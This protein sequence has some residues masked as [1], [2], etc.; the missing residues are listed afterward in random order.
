MKRTSPKHCLT[1]ELCATLF[2]FRCLWIPTVGLSMRVMGF[3]SFPS[4]FTLPST[5]ATLGTTTSN[6]RRPHYGVSVCCVW[7][8]K[9]ASICVLCVITQNSQYL[10]VVCDY[11]KQPV[12][13]CCVWL[14]KTASICVWLLKT[15]SICVWLL[16]AA[17]ICVLCMI[18][19]NGQYSPYCTERLSCL[20]CG[21]KRVWFVRFSAVR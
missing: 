6:I 2:G 11:S 13:V 14:L 9:T 15:A 8:L 3:R 4:D 12:F 17:S 20:R 19:Q 21:M 10:C 7:L 16:K 1:I 5:T 18:T